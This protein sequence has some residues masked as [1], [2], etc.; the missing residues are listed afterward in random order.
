MQRPFLLALAITWAAAALSLP[1][2]APRNP[3]ETTG[4]F[5]PVALQRA[6]LSGKVTDAVTGRGVDGAVLEVDP[7]L[8]GPRI[9][10]N[11]DGFYYAEF[12]GGSYRLRFVREGYRSAKETVLLAPGQTAG[13]DVSLHPTAPVVVDAG[14]TVSNAS[15]GSTVTVRARVTVRDGSRAKGIRWDA[16][17]EE[18]GVPAR[19]E[20]SDTAAAQVTLPGIE[21]YRRALLY[22]L[23]RDG[24]LHD[25][26]EVVG[27]A[28]A[29][30]KGAG[31]VTLTVAAA[32]TSGTYSDTVDII[33]DL[34]GIAGV[35]PGLRN[36]AVGEPVFLN[37]KEQS[38][39][40]WTLVRPPSSAAAM[41]NAA[42]R[43]PSF[44]PDIPGTYLVR[45]G[46]TER[47]TVYAGTWNGVVAARETE[48]RP[49]WI[50]V[51]GCLCH[52]SD[53]VASRFAAWRTS[54]HA[55]IFTRCADSIF[56]YEERCFTCHTVGFGGMSPGGGMSAAPSYPGFLKDQTLWDHGETPPVI[57]PRPGNLDAMIDTYPD[58]ARLTNVQ[59][60]NCHGPNNSPAHA[61]RK[62][63]GAPERISLGADA[64]AICHDGSIE[65]SF[66][67]WLDNDHA[68]YHLAVETAS[69]E[70][71]GEAAGDC[72]RCHSGQ[73]FLAWLARG[74]R[75]APLAEP[76]KGSAR[77]ELAALGLAADKVQPV[78]CAACHDPHASGSSF[79]SA[80]EKV[81]LRAADYAGML[82][83]EFH[84]DTGGRGAVCI[85]CH[86]TTPG[87]HNDADLP[88]IA[89][90]AAPH[91]SQSD[92]MFGQNAF[93]TEVGAYRSHARIEDTCVW[94]HAKPVPKPSGSGY[95]RGG[96]SHTLRTE[97]GLCARCH[98][99][100]AGDE[101]MTV[102][103]RDVENL[104]GA[105]ED[106]LAEEIRR[107]GEVRLAGAGA[108]VKDVLLRGV[109]GKLRLIELE[110]S[111][112]V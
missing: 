59:C 104:R 4:F 10:S 103:E 109:S 16:Q 49:R 13:R 79:R 27:L 55:E 61:T 89:A 107:K 41:G 111:M 81:P 40:A 72:G 8:A 82:P 45:E 3:H 43:N 51:K 56:R 42:T 96:V 100:F 93:F 9:V 31:R 11:R 22:R 105:I 30:L 73:G 110:G 70:R 63:S 85:T 20:G 39:Y 37:G 19:V 80:T 17:S 23:R 66:R 91:A 15:P 46:G 99:E 12:P 102:T 14:K 47:L 92:V 98:K 88:R 77:R 28:P 101:L 58:V 38:S 54:G 7:P 53:P 57:R 21:E 86:S 76:G 67:Q 95:P 74:N 69:V 34:R 6:C 108:G 32:T 50:G 106:A 26:W 1:G 83:R 75:F 35:N 65:P 84:N 2:C 78:T 64:C 87:P 71:R 68:N 44:T 36:V 33:A 94:C 62:K 97:A 29:D 90:D 18:G 24:R 52:Y 25:R 48:I 112:A 60:E 5:R